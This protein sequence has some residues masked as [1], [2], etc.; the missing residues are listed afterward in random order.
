MFVGEPPSTSCSQCKLLQILYNYW[1]TKRIPPLTYGGSRI[2]RDRFPPMN[3]NVT[4]RIMAVGA[5]GVFGLVLVGV[6]YFYGLWV[7]DGFR[8]ASDD[9]ERIAGT[10]LKLQVDLLDARRLEKDFLLR[11]EL[12]HAMR[13]AEISRQIE[14]NMASLRERA[15]AIVRIKLQSIV[16]S[17]T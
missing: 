9:A 17:T 15:H 1:L 12:D 7:Q 4:R 16:D 8:A 14:S 6:L 10:A 3:M 13:L 11:R 5:V 2:L